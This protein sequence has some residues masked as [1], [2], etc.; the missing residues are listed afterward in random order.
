MFYAQH[1][2]SVNRNGCCDLCS[3]VLEITVCETIKVH[4]W[5]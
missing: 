3:Q 5:L 4:G 1:W 2:E